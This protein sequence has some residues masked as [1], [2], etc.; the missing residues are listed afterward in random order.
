MTKE[1]RFSDVECPDC[2]GTGFYVGLTEREPCKTCAG[3]PEEADD[4]DVTE[5]MKTDWS[6]SEWMTNEEYSMIY[7]DGHTF[8]SL[9][10]IVKFKL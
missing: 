8:R 5:P 1:Q 3:V 6:E 10:S 7:P 9:S 2:K 4:G